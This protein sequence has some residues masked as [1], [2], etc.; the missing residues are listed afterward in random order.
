[1][2]PPPRAIPGRPI[3][4]NQFG[5]ESEDN[6]LDQILNALSRFIYEGS[7]STYKHQENPESEINNG[8]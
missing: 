3:G 6:L 2:S 7:I 4:R 1:M 8:N 5:Y